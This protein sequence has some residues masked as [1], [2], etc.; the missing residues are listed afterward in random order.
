VSTPHD[1][2]GKAVLRAA[3]SEFSANADAT[4]VR[5][6]SGGFTRIDGV[7]GTDVAVE[8][9][10]RVSKQVR[11]AIVDL[12]LHPHPLKL[13]VLLPST[14]PTLRSARRRPRKSSF[15]YCQTG[16]ARWCCWVGLEWSLPLSL[17]QRW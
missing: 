8:V 1:E 10:S 4:T 13:L 6:Q 11:G 3:D 12:V 14:C 2:Y 9:E 15:D 16:A 5:F 7:V 17:M